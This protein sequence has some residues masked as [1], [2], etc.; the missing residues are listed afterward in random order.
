M[1]HRTL[2]R[3]GQPGGKPIRGLTSTSTGA[4][5]LF[6]IFLYS[7]SSLCLAVTAT[8]HYTQSVWPRLALKDIPVKLQLELMGRF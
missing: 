8:T 4:K 7:S 1:G 6:L 5:G 2:F 3:L